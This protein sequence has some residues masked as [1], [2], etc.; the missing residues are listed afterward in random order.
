MGHYICF[1]VDRSVYRLPTWKGC[2]RE[3]HPKLVVIEFRY[4]IYILHN[5]TVI[6]T[7]TFAQ[8]D[9]LMAADITCYRY[10]MK[11]GI[12]DWYDIPEMEQDSPQLL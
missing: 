7:K 4:N 2:E 10:L 3:M 9:A 12:S 5:P 11:E 6:D 1:G 8:I